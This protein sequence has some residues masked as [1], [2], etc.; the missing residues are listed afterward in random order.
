MYFCSI[1]SNHYKRRKSDILHR[2]CEHWLHSDDHYRVVVF[3]S[4]LGGRAS[5][6]SGTTTETTS[7]TTVTLSIQ[8]AEDEP[9]NNVH[10]AEGDLGV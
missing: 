10:W 4:A 8:G 9:H 2:V 1:L 6:S 3:R 7:S 5:S